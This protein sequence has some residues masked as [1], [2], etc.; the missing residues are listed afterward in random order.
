MQAIWIYI[1][2]A[3]ASH[4]ESSD[5]VHAQRDAARAEEGEDEDEDDDSLSK[6]ERRR[7]RKAEEMEA[8]EEEGEEVDDYDKLAQELATD[9]KARAVD[10]F[11]SVCL[12]VCLCVMGLSRSS[13][14][15]LSAAE[16]AGD[17]LVLLARR[18]TLKGVDR[19]VRRL[20]CTRR[21]RAVGRG[22]AQSIEALALVPPA[23]LR[24]LHRAGAWGNAVLSRA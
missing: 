5:T 19:P 7:K 18:L 3:I 13:T 4:I 6:K 15:Q 17:S 20:C 21:L 8:A 9:M 24:L 12:C 10:R 11:V 22:L 14:L 2:Y 1:Q 16:S 23:L